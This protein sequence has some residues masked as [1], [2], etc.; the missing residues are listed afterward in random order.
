[1]GELRKKFLLKKGSTSVDDDEGHRRAKPI[2]RRAFLS[3]AIY[4]IILYTALGGKKQSKKEKNLTKKI[5]T[6]LGFG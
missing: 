5:N 3:S 1:M 4:N 2:R 6:Q